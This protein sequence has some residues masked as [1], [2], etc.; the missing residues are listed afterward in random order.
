MINTKEKYPFWITGIEDI[1]KMLSE[2]RNGE[3]TEL[4]TSAGGRIVK[5][6]T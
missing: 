1:E 6:V 4:C 2:V 5:Y 3:V